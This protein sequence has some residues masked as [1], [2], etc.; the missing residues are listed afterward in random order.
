MN[1]TRDDQTIAIL[2]KGNGR[3]KQGKIK[4]RRD[5]QKKMNE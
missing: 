3:I 1:K 5:L 2:A 4:E